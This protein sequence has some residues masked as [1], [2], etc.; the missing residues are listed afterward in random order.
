MKNNYDISL[1][2]KKE[3]KNVELF[4]DEMIQIINNFGNFFKIDPNKKIILDVTF[5]SKPKIRKLNKEY[6][7]KDYVTDILSFDFGNLEFYEKMPFIHLGELIISWDKMKKQAKEFN[8]SIKREYC[9][10]FTHGLVHLYGYDH[11]LEEERVVMNKIVDEIFE[12]LKI[13]RED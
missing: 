11:E 2:I 7:N 12:P 10:L 13:K 5:V 8:H 9:Y 4:K 1:N 6:R 3:V